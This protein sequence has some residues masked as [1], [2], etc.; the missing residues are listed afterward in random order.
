[1]ERC[2]KLVDIGRR[3]FLEGKRICRGRSGD[4]RQP[5]DAG[6]GGAWL[7]LVE[8]P[9]NRLANVSDLKPNEPLEVVVS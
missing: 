5:S 7:A 2:N 4:G 1:M 8:Y 6:Q 3:Q 9:S